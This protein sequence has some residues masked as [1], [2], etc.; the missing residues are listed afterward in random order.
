MWDTVVLVRMWV[1][2]PRIVFARRRCRR[3]LLSALGPHCCLC[4]FRTR[5]RTPSTLGRVC[6][7]PIYGRPSVT[8]VGEGGERRMSHSARPRTRA[9]PCGRD[10][11]IRRAR[12]GRV[13]RK[14][15]M[16]GGQRGSRDNLRFA[17]QRGGARGGNL[18]VVFYL[19]GRRRH[20]R[21]CSN[22]L[23]GH[24]RGPRA[25]ATDNDCGGGGGGAK[26][27][28]DSDGRRLQY[29]N[30]ARPPLYSRTSKT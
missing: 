10:G 7:M 16:D 17:M 14:Y 23:A 29:A 4:V 18:A 3:R 2:P 8:G 26:S 9:C 6:S 11:R 15:T 24:R 27:S 25:S 19:L 5:G 13:R 28:S 21:H 30:R 20:R 12:A 22:R 1:G